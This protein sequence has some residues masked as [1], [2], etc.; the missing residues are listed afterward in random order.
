MRLAHVAALVIGLTSQ[1]A[2]QEIVSAR[3]DGPTT[4]YPHGVLGDDIEYDT[5]VVRLSDGREMSARWARDI[6]FEDLAPRVVDVDGDGAP[7]V[8]VVESHEAQGARLAVWGLVDGSLAAKAA[9]P[10][11]G[12]RFRWLAP[13]AVADL[14]GD[15]LVELAYVDRPHL[16]KVLRVWRYEAL[17][18]GQVGLTEVATLDGVTNHRIGWDYIAGGLRDCGQGPEIVLADAG[19]A[20]IVAV[21]F[22]GTS[23]RRRRLGDYTAESLESALYC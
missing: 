11:I 19:W 7:E 15:G 18:T 5:L 23:L 8:V 1:S 10:F 20:S 13:A 22:D 9:T 12:T 14:D 6:V 3:Y 21:T 2:A 17:N 4:R 16:A